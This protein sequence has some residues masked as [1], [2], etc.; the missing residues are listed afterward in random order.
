M[1]RIMIAGT[2]SG[3]G[4]T[5][6]TCAILAAMK[7]MNENVI[8]FKV[9]PDY[10][11]PMVHKKIT[12]VEA[13]N[14]D[15]VLMG[16][17]NVKRSLAN[18]RWEFAVI[19]GVMG[20]YDGV[21]TDSFASSNHLSVLTDTPV[22]L[23]VNTKGK[24]QSVCAEIGGY[25]QFEK[26]NI[27]AV[28]LN[29]T[30][31]SMY[32]FYKKMIEEK[33]AIHVIGFMPNLPDAHFES[34]HLGLVTASEIADLKSKIALLS[35]QA[36]KTIDLEKLQAIAN[37]AKEISVLEN[38]SY[39]KNADKPKIYISN[40]EA[41]CF[42]YDDNL[43]LLKNLGAE[44]AFFSPLHDKE[45]PDDADGIILWG[46]YPE[47]YAEQLSGNKSMTDSIKQRIK[48]GIPVYAECGGFMYLQ[49]SITDLNSVKTEML[50]VIPSHAKMTERLQNFGYVTLTAKTDNILC[51]AG[52]TINAHSFH[53]SVSSFEGE[54]FIAT[55]MSGGKTYPCIVATKQI[56]AGYPHLHFMGNI[57]FAQNFILGCVR[58]RKEGKHEF[59]NKPKGN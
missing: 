8:S 16:E 14:L 24:S 28:I 3:C 4:K 41:F 57:E 39:E 42:Y 37:T 15:L 47:L 7:D 56:F 11:D 43:Q 32:P 50:G 51:K 2:G 55:K 26:N 59:N 5:T 36:R 1:S 33:L 21:G 10:I 44:L 18:N 54:S 58:Y 20:L 52:T 9:G 34:R 22:I 30:S 12:E 19:E 23:V 38:Q 46:G 53:H 13:R 40:D 27:S 25:L 29:N 49:E 35:H 6:I 45:I 48:S 17:E 31:E